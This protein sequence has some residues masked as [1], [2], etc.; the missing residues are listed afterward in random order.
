MIKLMNTCLTIIRPDGQII[1]LKPR[2]EKFTLEELQ[3]AVSK[4]GIRNNDLIEIAPADRD[5]FVVLVNEEGL[6]KDM[7]PNLP[8]MEYYTGPMFV[9]PVVF[10]PENLME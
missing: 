2:S 1:K 7:E 9:G 3:D 8:A 4:N 5:G 10:V 6:Y